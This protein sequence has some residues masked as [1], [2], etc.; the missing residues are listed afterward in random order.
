M[1][2][3]HLLRKGDNMNTLKKLFLTIFALAFLL[4]PLNAMAKGDKIPDPP[5]KTKYP[6]VLAHG[7]ALNDIRFCNVLVLEYFHGVK[8]RLE[9]NGATVFIVDV[10]KMAATGTKAYQFANYLNKN[11]IGK[12]DRDGNKI[13]RVNIIGH[14]HG[15]IYSKYA[16]KFQSYYSPKWGYFSWNLP[17]YRL[18]S[19]TQ[20]D[21]PNQGSPGVDFAV[22]A[23]AL[24]QGALSWGINTTYTDLF[25]F[26]FGKVESDVYSDSLTNA[27]DMTLDGAA[28]MY[29]ALG[30]NSI[31]G[32]YCQS[33][34][35]K[36]KSFFGFA[37]PQPGVVQGMA[38]TMPI[39]AY[40]EAIGYKSDKGPHMP[41][42][43]GVSKRS[44]SW[45][46]FRG[47]DDGGWLQIAGVDHLN[48]TGQPYGFTGWFRAPDKYQDIVE[49][50]KARGY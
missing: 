7:I 47:M 9:D 50:L 48:A 1:Q 3:A 14:S 19:I 20:I 16:V 35:H 39:Q 5:C 28:N 6:I 37:I 21:S 8:K 18:A 30:G 49:D 26:F 40:A 42:D 23:D 25:G 15:G 45:G 11:V 34:T 27:T 46:N 12:Y 17:K 36:M 38:L 2:P 22:G 31:S 44:A 41:C 13:E 10:D 24:T 33:Y 4:A 43:G 32:I 29:T